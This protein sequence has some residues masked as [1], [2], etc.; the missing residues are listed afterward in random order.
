MYGTKVMI[1]F[2]FIEGISLQVLYRFCGYPY[3]TNIID[4]LGEKII[5]LEGNS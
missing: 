2:I 4:R 5:D 1:I 3:F